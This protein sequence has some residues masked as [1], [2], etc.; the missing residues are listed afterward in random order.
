MS[1]RK[2]AA[3][4]VAVIAATCMLVPAAAYNIAPNMQ[5]ALGGGDAANAAAALMAVQIGVTISIATLSKKYRLVIL[6]FMLFSAWAAYKTGQHSHANETAGANTKITSEGQIAGKLK[7]LTKARNTFQSFK[8][9]SQETADADAKTYNDAVN[10]RDN[11]A[12]DRWC[13]SKA[14][15]DKPVSDAQK[16]MTT[17]LAQRKLTADYEKITTAI[18]A[19]EEELHGLGYVPQHADILDAQFAAMFNNH[20]S[21]EQVASAQ[22]AFVA[23]I[24]ELLNRFG[25]MT[26]FGMVLL[27]FGQRTHEE[28]EEER[29]L[30]AIERE[31]ERRIREH[32][33]VVAE[34]KAKADAERAIQEAKAQLAREEADRKAQAELEQ[35]RRDAELLAT[36]LTSP[37]EAKEWRKLEKANGELTAQRQRAA[38]QTRKLNDKQA[39]KRNDA[40]EWIE[41]FITEQTCPLPPGIA[42]M[43][44]RI[45]M[46][47]F[48]E[49][50]NRWIKAKGGTCENDPI[51]FGLIL[52]DIDGV[53][54]H[55]TD[56]KR[57]YVI[58]RELTFG[59]NEGGRFS[60][61][62]LTLNSLMA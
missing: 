47:V 43:D 35:K 50:C 41:R 29:R 25:P 52:K 18:E 40:A 21:E 20:I 7:E 22:I 26:A 60:L 3:Q 45:E 5:V 9:T 36:P 11:C 56:G 1:N 42:L 57:S 13:K 49:T 39:K 61:N 12:K 46:K 8:P 59:M 37:K 28:E 19:K 16:T 62:S 48:R 55:K 24:I 58:G 38:K 15:K 34:V 4:F 32:E 33:L 54:V 6:A 23:F 2:A 27:A 44:A 51:K 30:A 17:T 14:A 10:A 53:H 31:T